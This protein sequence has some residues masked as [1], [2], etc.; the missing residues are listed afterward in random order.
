M[1]QS[2][3]RKMF[4]R[5]MPLGMAANDPSW[6]QT[7][8]PEM[9]QLQISEFDLHQRDLGAETAAALQKLVFERMQAELSRNETL[10]VL[11]AGGFELVIQDAAE[12]DTEKLADHLQDAVI[13]EP[14]SLNRC[15][16]ECELTS[17]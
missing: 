2:L 13:G 17:P 6:D 15:L 4:Q 14:F 12:V 5:A 10:V 11:P 8:D 9:L 3:F 16:I 1:A 7:S